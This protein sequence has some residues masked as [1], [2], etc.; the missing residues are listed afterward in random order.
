M[1]GSGT[2]TLSSANTYSGDTIV[3]AGQLNAWADSALGN[4]NVFVNNA[5]L[6]LYQGT[7]TV[8]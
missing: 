2:L 7:T 1:G 3:N 6:N 5:T 8:T 4:G